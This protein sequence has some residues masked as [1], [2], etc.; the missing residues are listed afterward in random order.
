[1]SCYN[2]ALQ[3]GKVQLR[4]SL[5]VQPLLDSRSPFCYQLQKELP[6]E[7]L[8][9]SEPHRLPGPLR[10]LWQATSPWSLA[11]LEFDWHGAVLGLQELSR[12]QEYASSPID[13]SL[14]YVDYDKLARLSQV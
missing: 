11:H 8:A 12:R 9:D 13:L 5:K 10:L 3:N 1:M 4:Q 14:N 6:L 7:G 2:M